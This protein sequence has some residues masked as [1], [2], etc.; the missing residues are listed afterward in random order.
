MA[1]QTPKQRLANE[2]F[3]K[4]VEKQRKFGK[5]KQDKQKTELPISKSWVYF[6]LFLLIGGGVLELFSLLF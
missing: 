5:K 3:N 4:N 2:K 1:V 6:I